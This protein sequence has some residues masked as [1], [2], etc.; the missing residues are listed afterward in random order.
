[1]NDFDADLL[2]LL[3]PGAA[4]PA[5]AQPEPQEP[6]A[7]VPELDLAALLDPVQADD[8]DDSSTQFEQATALQAQAPEHIAKLAEIAD[9]R[10]TLEDELLD[11]YQRL[12]T[13]RELLKRGLWAPGHVKVAH[14][15]VRQIEATTWAWS[16][17]ETEAWRVAYD[18]GLIP[19]FP[20]RAD[21]TP[22]QLL[23]G[24][25]P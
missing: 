20:R 14:G 18:T 22:F 13:A 12:D 10:Q 11:L 16:W 3:S 17:T 7:A 19:P 25:R 23:E 1:M 24:Q 21:W 2:A 5:P 8:F 9:R 6:A 4:S 15:L